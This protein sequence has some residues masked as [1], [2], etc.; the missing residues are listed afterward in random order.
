M[1]IGDVSEHNGVR[2]H[3]DVLRAIHSGR[4][5]PGDIPI[6]LGDQGL[7]IQHHHL[8]LDVAV[9]GGEM[10]LISHGSGCLSKLSSVLPCCV[11][12]GAFACHGD[13]VYGAAMEVYQQQSYSWLKMQGKKG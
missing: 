11:S 3:D 1:E 5:H 4:L 7:A 2:C 6:R 9:F 13:S 10:V 8:A 12:M